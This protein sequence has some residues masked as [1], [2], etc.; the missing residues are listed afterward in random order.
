MIIFTL[1]LSKKA[2]RMIKYFNV[3]KGWPAFV[4]QVK[5]T[6]IYSKMTCSVRFGYEK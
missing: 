4:W 2:P 6:H 3:N 1:Q 5:F